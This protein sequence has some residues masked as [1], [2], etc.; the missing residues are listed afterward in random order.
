MDAAYV[1]KYIQEYYILKSE[2]P[3]QEADID[4]CIQFCEA[5]RDL[6]INKDAMVF[7][8]FDA[9]LQRLHHLTQKTTV[10]RDGEVVEIKKDKE[11]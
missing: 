8:A 9:L 2:Q 5:Q 3:K 4:D 1:L 11:L 6:Y 10:P 7:M